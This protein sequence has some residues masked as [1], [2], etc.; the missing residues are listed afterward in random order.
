MEFLKFSVNMIAAVIMGTLYTFIAGF[1]GAFLAGH[2]LLG[3]SDIASLAL[4]PVAVMVWALFLE[5]WQK[6]ISDLME[7]NAV[8]LTIPTWIIPVIA[9]FV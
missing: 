4:M 8:I 6:D 9:S 5:E 3:W 7:I 2:F 1:L